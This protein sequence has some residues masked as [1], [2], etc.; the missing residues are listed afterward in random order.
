M[1]E[2]QILQ[3]WK[4]YDAKVE[5]SLSINKKLLKDSLE[6]KAASALRSLKPVRW[7]G[8]IVGVL[9]CLAIG[10]IVVSSWGFTT[11]YFKASL[12][13]NFII[14]AIAI[15]LYIYHLV[16]LHQFDNSQQVVE[17]QQKLV[18]LQESN[19][20]TL[21]ILLLQ[22]PVYSTWFITDEWIQ[23]SPSTFWGI[24]MPIVLIQTWIGIW[25]FRNLNY[26][27]YNKKWFQWF[28]SKGEFGRIQKAMNFLKEVEEIS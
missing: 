2:A 14:T 19:L 18:Q 28:V 23:N 12:I 1:E 4:L 8:I 3:L 25:L 27:N 24:Q 20:R 5:Q 21:G 7:T 6:R 13:I 10:V 11:I 17:A 26:K 15:G 16:L 9:W 22:L